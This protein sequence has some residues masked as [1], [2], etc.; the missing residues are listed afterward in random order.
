MTTATLPAAATPVNPT[1]AKSAVSPIVSQAEILQAVASGQMTVE[2][3]S[4]LLAGL[5]AKSSAPPPRVQARKTAKGALWVSLGY[6]AAPGCQNSVTLPR[7][8]CEAIVKLVNDGTIPKL[9]ADWDNVPL[10]A[11]AQL[12]GGAA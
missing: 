6:R 4:P 8:G 1:P 11:S 2:Q 7:K 10:S 5:S 9:L 3:A 12:K